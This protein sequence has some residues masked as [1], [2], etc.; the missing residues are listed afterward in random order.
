MVK[1]RPSVAREGRGER[2]PE[3]SDCRLDEATVMLIESA[4]LRAIDWKSACWEWD[5]DWDWGPA[6]ESWVRLPLWLELRLGGL[7][8]SLL[9]ASCSLLTAHGSQLTAR[10]LLLAARCC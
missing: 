1:V 8:C 10:D 6:S 7:G 3:E 5:L 4:Q 9:S 2:L